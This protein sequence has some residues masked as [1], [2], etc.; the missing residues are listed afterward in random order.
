MS[1]QQNLSLAHLAVLFA[2]IVVSTS[3]PI[4]QRIAPFLD[5]VLIVLSR[6]IISILVMLPILLFTNKIK[7]PTV[8]RLFQ[9]GLV[10]GVNASFFIFMFTALKETTSLN[11]SVIY[12]LVPSLTALISYF[13]LKEKL[14]RVHFILIP[15]GLLATLW[16]I[17]QGSWQKAMDF[18]LNHG[19]LIFGVGC[20]LIGLNVTLLKKFHTGGSP[21][22]IVFWSMLWG[23]ILLAG[24]S[25]I[26]PMEIRLEGIPLDVYI[27]IIYLGVITVFTSFV[28]AYGSPIIGPMKTTAYSYSIP[29]LVLFINWSLLDQLPAIMVFPGVL[30][31]I[32]IMFFLQ[33][34]GES[35]KLRRTD[36]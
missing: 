33:M 17:F 2:T 14:R 5:P 6:F 15:L 29:S 35:N 19:D 23:S 36:D 20:L 7:I 4:G 18:D 22:N 3:F 13:I 9:F 12:T 1:K 28:W 31:G 32:V 21:I 24:Y 10:G 8:R 34:S 16:V 30:I 25:L 26:V 11:T 27:W